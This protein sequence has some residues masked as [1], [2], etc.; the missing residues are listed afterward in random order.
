MSKSSPAVAPWHRSAPLPAP[1]TSAAPWQKP[2]ALPAPPKAQWPGA[3]GAPGTAPGTAGFQGIFRENL[4]EFWRKKM[5]D[6]E[7][8]SLKCIAFI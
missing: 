2:A 4:E 5:V 3:P 8:L 6:F 1:P 7:V